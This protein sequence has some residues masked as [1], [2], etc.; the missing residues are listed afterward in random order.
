MLNAWILTVISKFISSVKG[1]ESQWIYT[2]GMEIWSLYYVIYSHL[3]ISHEPYQVCHVHLIQHIRN[4]TEYFTV[5]NREC[6]LLSGPNHK[7]SFVNSETTPT[8]RVNDTA[9][10]LVAVKK[11]IGPV[12]TKTD[13]F[14]EVANF[15]VQFGVGT[16]RFYVTGQTGTTRNPPNRSGSYRFLLTL[17][18]VRADISS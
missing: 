1:T 14:A 5:K 8:V 2:M 15:W 4:T 12:T 6:N 3:G 7:P 10:R 17:P 9:D 13:W 16:D 11:K 18:T